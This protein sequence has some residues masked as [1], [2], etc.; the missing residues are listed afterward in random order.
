[1]S[2]INTLP[3]AASAEVAPPPILTAPRSN[4]IMSVDALRGLV[5]L[6]MIFV[7]DI[8]HVSKKIVPWWMRHYKGN[9]NGMTFVDLVFPAFL[10]IV[11]M[12]IPFAL[13]SRLEK[14]EPLWKI[15]LRVIGRTLALLLL[16]IMMVNE[17]PDS[18]KMGWS[19]TLWSALMLFS[20]IFA[21][22][23]LSPRSSAPDARPSQIWPAV[24]IVL[25]CL[26]FVSLIYLAFAFRGENDERIIS[27]SPF[28][29]RT[30]WYGILG[31]I[32][33]AY[34][35]TSIVFLV[36]RTNRTAL[37]GCMVLLFCL[38][39]ADRKGT[40]E[41]FWLGD[42]VGIGE[43]LGSQA[44]I[45]VAGVLLASILVTSNTSTIG[46]RTRFTL[47]FI[48][49]CSS[50]ALL[51][52]RLYGIN[53]NNATLSWCLWACAITA[54]LWLVFYF[55]AD[56]LALRFPAKLLA[57]AGANVLLAYLLADLREPVFELLHLDQWY[58]HLA[59]PGLA[60]A[61][62]RSLGCA[63]VILALSVGLNR[64]GF[65]LKL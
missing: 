1:M 23:S 38:Y 19:D 34:L 40:F 64:I 14:G 2:P 4:R 25:R 28:S 30:E 26:G 47:L 39:P 57:F 44:A 15:V 35:V 45:A 37:L 33:W 11:G 6:T 46:A 24:T 65:R 29:I 41:D 55:L 10:F 59:Q 16:G 52:H 49:G 17:S 61:I 50:A 18:D 62:G 53:K 7:N 54:A 32:G 42:Y 12:S 22:C 20:A 36:F 51:L 5:M 13:G 58:V 56:V 48:A 63:I 9:G 21:F 8:G 43:T 31:L 60:N 27:L 3:S